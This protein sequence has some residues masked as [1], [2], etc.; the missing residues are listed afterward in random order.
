MPTTDKPLLRVRYRVKGEQ[1][2]EIGGVRRDN[3][4]RGV[5]AYISVYGSHSLRLPLHRSVDRPR[6]RESGRALRSSAP[7]EI[8]GSPARH[9]DTL[10]SPPSECRHVILLPRREAAEI[11]P[12]SCQGPVDQPGAEDRPAHPRHACSSYRLLDLRI[13][14]YQEPPALRKARYAMRSAPKGSQALMRL[15]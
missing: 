12:G 3:T 1:K 2:N 10:A 7:P 14:D 8:R 13:A 9:C 11:A 5:R 6:R 4:R 15:A